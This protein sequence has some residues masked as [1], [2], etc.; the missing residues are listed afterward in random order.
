LLLIY[1][2]ES[3]LSLWC[4]ASPQAQNQ[5]SQ[6]LWTEIFEIVS[7]INSSFPK[8]FKLFCQSHKVWIIHCNGWLT[9]L[10]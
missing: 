3:S 10:T 8:L 6:G 4:S 9:M 1:H 7:K 5:W 2:K